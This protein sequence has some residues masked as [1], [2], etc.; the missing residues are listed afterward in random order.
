MSAT[1]TT[2]TASECF[3]IYSGSGPAIDNI[4]VYDETGFPPELLILIVAG[5]SVAIIVI[6]VV[7]YIRKR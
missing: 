2:Y 7:W 4:V 6:V 1:D 5:V 3:K